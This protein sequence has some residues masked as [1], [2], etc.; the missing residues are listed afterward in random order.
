V[1][2]T[3]P[4]RGDPIFPVT[5]YGTKGVASASNNPGGRENAVSWIDSGGSLWLF[6]GD[7]QNDLW[8]FSPRANTWT[9]VSG[10]NTGSAAGVYGTQGTAST[11]NVPAANGSGSHG[12][13]W[14]DTG[15]NLWLFGGGDLNALW[16]FSPAA[17]TWT[18]VSGNNTD[19]AL[20]VYGTQA[21]AS[22]SNVPGSRFGAGS[23]IDGNGSL[24][25][26]GGIGMDSVGPALNLN[27]LWRYEPK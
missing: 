5:V 9:W 19:G 20:G 25:L 6:G 11:S 1:S 4:H 17:N 27:D 14:I 16:K 24:W 23:W 8:K 13:N 26:F 2:G 18:W 22:A 7:D 3:G 15:G 12:V 21:T 10:S